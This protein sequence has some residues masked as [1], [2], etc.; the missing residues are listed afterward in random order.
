MQQPHSVCGVSAEDAGKQWLPPRRDA[1]FTRHAR[2][3]MG[4][5]RVRTGSAVP[6]DLAWARPAPMGEGPMGEAYGWGLAQ[7]TLK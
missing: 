1:H 4:S 5:T 3:W 2:M 7:D 6:Q